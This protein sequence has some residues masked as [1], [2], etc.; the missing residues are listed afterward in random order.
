MCQVDKASFFGPSGSGTPL[1]VCLDGCSS[2]ADCNFVTHSRSG[3]CRYWYGKPQAP[4]PLVDRRSFRLASCN[5][6]EGVLCSPTSLVK[7]N[8]PYS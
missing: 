1:E 2:V 5:S 6:A 8:H 3:Y 7:S 4:P